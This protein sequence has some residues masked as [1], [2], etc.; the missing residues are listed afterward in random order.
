MLANREVVFGETTLESVAEGLTLSLEFLSL[1]VLL[2]L[3]GVQSCV[4][5][6]LIFSL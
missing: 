5:E 4:H 6:L 2:F 1:L 3:E